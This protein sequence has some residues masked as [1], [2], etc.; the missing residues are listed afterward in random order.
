MKRIYEKTDHGNK[1]DIETNFYLMIKMVPVDKATKSSTGS[2]LLVYFTQLY[3]FIS[4]SIDVLLTRCVKV[5]FNDKVRTQDW[6]VFVIYLNHWINFFQ[7][8]V[9]HTKS[10][11]QI[12]V[13]KVWLCLI[14]QPGDAGVGSGNMKDLIWRHWMKGN[15]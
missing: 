8:P 7:V 10:C 6:K 3:L 15:V 12:S 9:F 11:L 4:Y 1:S 14:L 5:W 2:L 13:L